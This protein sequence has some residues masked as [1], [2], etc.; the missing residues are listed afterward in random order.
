M[1]QE[2]KEASSKDATPY[3]RE[4]TQKLPS[5]PKRRGMNDKDFV[6]WEK[7]LGGQADTPIK[8]IF[9]KPKRTHHAE[10]HDPFKSGNCLRMIE[11]MPQHERAK[12]IAIAESKRAQVNRSG[13]NSMV[14]ATSDQLSRKRAEVDRLNDE[15]QERYKELQ[16]HRSLADNKQRRSLTTLTKPAEVEASIKI[17]EVESPTKPES[18][19][20]TQSGG[21]DA[22][23]V[24]STIP[25][26]SSM[27]RNCPIDQLE[28]FHVHSE[29]SLSSEAM[30]VICSVLAH[31]K[32]LN[33]LVWQGDRILIAIDRREWTFVSR[34]LGANP[35]IKKLV[36]KE[37]VEKL[38]TNHHATCKS[39][40]IPS[41]KFEQSVTIAVPLCCGEAL[42]CL[43]E[44]ANANGISIIGLRTAALDAEEARK[45]P[46]PFVGRQILGE[47]RL[48]VCFRGPNCGETLRRILGP[49]DF[50]LAQRTDPH[51]INAKFDTGIVLPSIS[52]SSLKANL[53]FAFPPGSCS[54][55][56]SS[57]SLLHYFSAEDYVIEISLP[58][59]NQ[60]M[61]GVLIGVL[62]RRLGHVRRMYRSGQDRV[63]VECSSE[64]K[65]EL[66][67]EWLT[68]AI[69]EARFERDRQAGW[70]GP[71]IDRSPFEAARF[72]VKEQSG[73]KA[74]SRRAHI[75]QPELERVVMAVYG[76]DAE[77]LASPIEDLCTYFGVAATAERLGEI[78]APASTME[79]LSFEL[80]ATEDLEESQRAV[81]A[82]N[83]TVR[84]GPNKDPADRF[85]KSF[86]CLCI[87]QGRLGT[88]KVIQEFITTKWRNRALVRG[89]VLFTNDGEAAERIIS[90]LMGMCT[91]EPVGRR[92]KSIIGLQRFQGLINEVWLGLIP[93]TNAML[94]AVRELNNAG[95][96]ITNL[97]LLPENETVE[98]VKTITHRD[99]EDGFY[100]RDGEADRLWIKVERGAEADDPSFPLYEVISLLGPPSVKLSKKHSAPSLRVACAMGAHSTI[101]NPILCPST[102][103]DAVEVV[104]MISDQH[105]RACED[106][107]IAS[108]GDQGIIGEDSSVGSFGHLA[109]LTTLVIGIPQNTAADDA[110][111]F[112]CE[113]FED[114]K[115]LFVNTT[116]APSTRVIIHTEARMEQHLLGHET[117]RELI[118]AFEGEDVLRKGQKL[119]AAYTKMAHDQSDERNRPELSYIAVSK[120][121][122]SAAE[123]AAILC[124]HL[125]TGGRFY[126]V[127]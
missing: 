47:G 71:P 49:N 61:V 81:V 75:E 24:H 26:V 28:C 79:L 46:L 101:D 106:L 57:Q 52:S 50:N 2:M 93:H 118:L 30:R 20:P 96:S 53:D 22:G 17:E 80:C 21:S 66:S 92:S 116:C 89:D 125:A 1:R 34:E 31:S 94:K 12:F 62:L 73:P 123:D 29:E 109:E 37:A 108:P 87:L 19:S 104:R 14:S 36:N 100:N 48:L 84:Y 11:K 98:A 90:S 23:S 117:A 58:E 39:C 27:L 16:R 38:S 76:D 69:S 9:I 77:G 124:H 35:R 40:S 111:A 119:S 6:G 65:P 4:A 88:S 15:V 68:G 114:D 105:K 56:G 63:I 10:D 18:L 32:A 120:S 51:S 67:S 44:V 45:G 78:P 74:E 99:A 25:T 55:D 91:L 97:I 82:K 72:V 113:L 33:A 122:V 13:M 59:L 41:S 54:C 112:I 43:T 83:L 42:K 3:R 64:G 86:I 5:P 102:V 85:S 103:A 60:E 115:I 127:H 7:M 95:Y 8:D 126:L 121:R 107:A 110:M 70:A